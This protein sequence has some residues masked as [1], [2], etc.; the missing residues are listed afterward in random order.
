MS[1]S[2]STGGQLESLKSFKTLSIRTPDGE[3]MPVFG[4]DLA[5]EVGCRYGAPAQRMQLDP[6]DRLPVAGF[7]EQKRLLRRTNAIRLC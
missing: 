4:K 6:I 5:K 7:L 1:G 2:S 3:E